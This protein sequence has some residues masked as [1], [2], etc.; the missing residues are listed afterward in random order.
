[1]DEKVTCEWSFF[2]DAI[3]ERNQPC[4]EQMGEC[5]VQVEGTAN[6]KAWRGWGGDLAWLE[7]CKV[8][9]KRHRVP[10]GLGFLSRVEWL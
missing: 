3:F 1:M 6:A 4:T 10:E 5:F 8:V 7:M 2:E 9:L